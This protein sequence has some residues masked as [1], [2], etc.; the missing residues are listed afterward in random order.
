[1][2]EKDDPG[3][4]KQA[5][6][7]WFFEWATNGPRNMDLAPHQDRLDKI[8]AAIDKANKGVGA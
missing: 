7:A 4:L 3:Q 6:C 8:I 5:V 1:M 2:D